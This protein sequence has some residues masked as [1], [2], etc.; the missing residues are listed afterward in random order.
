MYKKLKIGKSNG[1]VTTLCVWCGNQIPWVSRKPSKCPFC[2]E[3]V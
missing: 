1:V 3:Q 2:G